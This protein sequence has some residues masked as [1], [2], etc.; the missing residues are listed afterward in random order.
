LSKKQL[1]LTAFLET[2]KQVKK[3]MC[4]DCKGMFELKDLII[5]IQLGN[6]AIYFCRPCNETYQ[7][8]LFRTIN[9]KYLEEK[10]DGK[11]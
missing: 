1:N 5:D 6:G 2:K 8:S 3:G 7:E 4:W 11:L 10:E 9:K